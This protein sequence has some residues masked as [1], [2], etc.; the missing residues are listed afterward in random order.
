MAQYS[1]FGPRASSSS[2]PFALD[3]FLPP[4]SGEE[5]EPPYDMDSGDSGFSRAGPN[6]GGGRRPNGSILQ[7]KAPPPSTAAN[8]GLPLLD[9]SVEEERVRDASLLILPLLLANPP[10]IPSH[11]KSTEVRQ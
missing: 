6:G 11:M 2:Q 7:Q 1:V 10:S 5:H 8:G 3:D 9:A 4:Q